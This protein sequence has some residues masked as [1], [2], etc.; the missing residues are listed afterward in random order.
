MDAFNSLGYRPVQH[1]TAQLRAKEGS[2]VMSRVTSGPSERTRPSSRLQPQSLAESTPVLFRLPTIDVSP[3]RLMEETDASLLPTVAA[4]QLETLA[5]N[6]L[7]PAIPQVESRPDANALE[8][9]ELT[10]ETPRSWWEHWSSGVVMIVLIIALVTLGIMIFRPS[11][12]PADTTLASENS[13]EE[14]GDLESISIPKIQSEEA[15]DLKSAQQQLDSNPSG[16][17]AFQEP[18]SPSLPSAANDLANIEVAPF[19]PAVPTDLS[20]MPVGNSSVPTMPFPTVDGI[21][22]EDQQLDPNQ[23]SAGPLATA[24]LLQPTPNDDPLPKFPTDP[25]VAAKGE[26]GA[27]SSGF[28]LPVSANSQPNHGQPPASE[29]SGQASSFSMPNLAGD[30]QGVQPNTMQVSGPTR[31]GI[32]SQPNEGRATDVLRN[33]QTATA[34][35][36]TATPESDEEEIIR[37]YLEL[38]GSAQ[39]NPSLDST[40]HDANSTQDNANRYQRK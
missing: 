6:S 17:A 33:D 36:S 1:A 37:A 21:P 25:S 19:D 32:E 39:P 28:A 14:F 3:F 11:G 12:S 31:S 38:T 26:S 15:S 5:H 9:S 27:A 10:S 8:S 35:R 20:G 24:T 2:I 18:V 23:I 40:I 29:P 16:S 34:V 7:S 30:L 22:I 4:L 13:H